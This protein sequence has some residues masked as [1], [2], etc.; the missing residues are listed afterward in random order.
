MNEQYIIID[1]KKNVWK[2]LGNL[3]GKV[4][5]VEFDDHAENLPIL[6]CTAIGRVEKI[7]PKF[8]KLIFWDLPGSKDDVRLENYEYY[9]IL[10]ASILR[11]RIFSQAVEMD[12]T[13]QR[14]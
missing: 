4:L 10:K 2:E 5:E 6:R 8:L 13:E 14:Q 1:H 7:T 12:L 3:K 11:I 9:S